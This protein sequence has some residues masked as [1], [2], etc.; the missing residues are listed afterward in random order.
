MT[1][2][3]DRIAKGLCPDCGEEAAPYYLCGDC[4]FKQQI[5]RRLNRAAK[6]GGFIKE[7]RGRETY[8]SIGAKGV[9][10]NMDW[11]DPK[12][13]DK[14]YRPR[15]AG[16]PVDVEDEIVK[17]LIRAGKPCTIEEIIAAWGQLRVRRT[18]TI[19]GNVARLVTAEQKRKRK[20]DRRK[21]M[22][23][24]AEIGLPDART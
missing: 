18:G 5:V 20:A 21:A 3:Q 23:A 6:A 24:P 15:L 2:R 8:W 14:R 19:A 4:R 1:K 11:R 9:V 13:G 17:L 22:A 7:K 12:P 10:E 16:V